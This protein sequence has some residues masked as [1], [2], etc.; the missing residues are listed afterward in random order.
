MDDT[1]KRR[2]WT[3]RYF[4]K[5]AVGDPGFVTLM[6]ASRQSLVRSSLPRVTLEKAE[7]VEPLTMTHPGGRKTV[8]AWCANRA[9]AG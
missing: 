2:P 9:G 1:F 5:D 6:Y 7:D 4:R 3:T 8:I